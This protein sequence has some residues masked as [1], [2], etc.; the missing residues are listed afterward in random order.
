MLGLITFY[1][2]VGK[3]VRAWSIP[4]GTTA[5]KAAGRIHSDMEEG[6][7]R[8]EVY[9]FSQLTEHGSEKKLSENGLIRSERRDYTVS[10]GDIIRFKFA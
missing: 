5:K 10:D 1:T 8:A 2:V 4:G 9:G 7:I 6:F 3:E